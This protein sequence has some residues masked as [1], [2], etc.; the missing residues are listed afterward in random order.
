MSMASKSLNIKNLEALG[1]QR[2]AELLIEISTGSAARKRRLRLELAG[3]QSAGEVA[4]EI[5]KRLGSIARA[6]TYIDW[7][8]VKP[9]KIDL[10]TQRA[11]I[12]KSV[13]GD[14]PDEAFDLIWQFLMLATSVFDR[15]NDGTG[16]LVGVFHQACADAG[17][18]ARSA[19]ITKKVLAEKVFAAFLDNGY[20]QF[21][22]LIREMAPALGN[23]G[24]NHL[25]AILSRHMEDA[26]TKPKDKDRRVIGWSTNGPI[27]QSD[28]DERLADL[29][30]RIALQEIADIQGDVDA[31]IALYTPKTR[32]VPLIAARI[33][34]RLLA[35]GRA[36]EALVV[37]DAA[38][39]GRV[40]S[41]F[42]WQ[43]AR[44]DA[45]EAL[46][47]GDEAQMFRWACFEKTLNGDHLRAHLR[48]LPDFD[49]L[50]AEEKA[51]AH[52]Q[53]FADVHYALSF[54]VSW[55]AFNEAAKLII[56]RRSQ[57]DGDLYELL[58]PASTLLAEKQPLAATV[59]LRA[60][61]DFTLDRARSSRYKHAA[62]HLAECEALSRRVVDYAG[63]PPHVDYL[64]EL[65]KRHGKKSGF[66]SLVP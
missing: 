6:R 11:T 51:F 17:T 46:E 50:E 21:D 52:A 58:T 33:A 29:T 64:L 20:G 23:E 40:T 5:R 48:R 47:R 39:H 55:P 35:A 44:V 49:D 27:D 19:S 28:L 60:M 2:L 8:K 42:E 41:P 62:H 37:L 34:E 22:P 45:L 31:Y 61:I 56:A 38:D 24:L 25:K 14:D 54:F 66:W 59:L 63:L 15:S 3:S 13:A 43:Q 18:I 26:K 4:R 53:A 10:E 30:G 65:K 36:K 1:A 57:I 16:A 32:K 9:L 7:Q 12:M